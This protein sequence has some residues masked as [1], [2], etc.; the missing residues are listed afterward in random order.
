[1]PVKLE[2]EFQY[3][4]NQLVLKLTET[5]TNDVMTFTMHDPKQLTTIING[6][7]RARDDMQRRKLIIP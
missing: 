5:S 7:L 2:M 6:M 4:E 1:M 3:K